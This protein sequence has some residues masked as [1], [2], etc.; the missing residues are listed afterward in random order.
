MKT[1]GE[2]EAEKKKGLNRE[3]A[4]TQRER[5]DVL[6]RIPL[7]LRDLAVQVF[8]S[9]PWRPEVAR[10]PPVCR[11]FSEVTLADRLRDGDRAASSRARALGDQNRAP[12]AGHL[13]FRT[14]DRHGPVAQEIRQTP[15]DG[16][17]GT[18]EPRPWC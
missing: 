5:K 7:C 15:P 3:G 4:K 16:A 14:R 9:T 10:P 8:G 6:L 12:V 18:S 11:L 17:E 1:G 13:D 2:G